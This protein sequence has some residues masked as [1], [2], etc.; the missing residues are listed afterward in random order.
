ML[1]ILILGSNSG[2]ICTNNEQTLTGCQKVIK[3]VFFG[4]EV[5][6]S[7]LYYF[8]VVITYCF[9]VPFSSLLFVNRQTRQKYIATWAEK[10]VNRPSFARGVDPAWSRPP[11]RRLNV[12]TRGPGA[13]HYFLQRL[14][15]SWGTGSNEEISSFC[16]VNLHYFLVVITY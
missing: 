12:P 9:W 4:Q 3:I 16:F 13:L 8:L 2:I 5:I 11:V 1:H 15:K 6:K 14:V 7:F 10:G